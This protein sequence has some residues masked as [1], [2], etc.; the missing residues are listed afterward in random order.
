MGYVKS[1]FTRPSARF[2]WRPRIEVSPS[3]F[4]RDCTYA[5]AAVSLPQLYC[6]LTLSVLR[7]PPPA[8]HNFQFPQLMIT[9]TYIP[10]VSFLANIYMMHH[11]CYLGRLEPF[12]PL[13]VVAAFNEAIHEP[14]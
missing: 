4:A 5:S 7:Q 3:L 8:K 6:F 12:E 2:C 10:P 9:I 14:V 11:L 13:D 1:G